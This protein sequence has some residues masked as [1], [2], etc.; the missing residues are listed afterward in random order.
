VWQ[1]VREGIA[2]PSVL[3]RK[4]REIQDE[5][6]KNNAGKQQSLDILKAHK[7]EL[8]AELERLATLYGTAM[9]ARIADKL[10]AEEAHKLELVELEIANRVHKVNPSLTNATIAGLVE[11]SRQFA[12]HLDAVEKTFTGRRTVIDGLDVRVT[13]LR[14]NGEIWLKMTS[15]LQP[16]GYLCTLFLVQK[17]YNKHSRKTACR[18]S[19]ASRAGCARVRFAIMRRG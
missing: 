14:K 8:E 9:P 13:V 16:E 6:Q 2:Q 1:W 12:E 3:E 10:I 15:L 19:N 5:Q 4:L 18:D 11:F 7:E 17:S